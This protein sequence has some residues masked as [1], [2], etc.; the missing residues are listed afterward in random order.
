MIT[1]QQ[2]CDAEGAARYFSELDDYYR[3]GG[4]APAELVGCGATRLGLAGAFD[5][6]RATA[7]AA[8][9]RGEVAGQRIGNPARHRA[10]YDLTFSA[11]KS[12]SV[13]ALVAGDDR[14]AAAHDRAAR[15]ALAHIEAHALVTR[16]RGADGKGYEWRQVEGIT[17]VFRHTTNRRVE[18]DLHSHIVIANAGY[19]QTTG[20]WASIDGKELFAAQREAGTLYMAELA[21][22]AREA[23]H[24]IDWTINAQGHPSF[25]IRD[26]PPELSLAFSTRTQAIEAELARRGLTRETASPDAKQAATLATRDKKLVGVDRAAL[27]ESWRALAREHGYD[28]DKRHGALIGNDQRLAAS[29]DAV[30]R[31][32]EHLSERDARFSRRDLEHECRIY[33]QGHA[34]DADLAAAIDRAQRRGD[35]IQRPSWGRTAGGQRGHRSGFTTAEGVKTERALLETAGKLERAN[36]A[37]LIDPTGKAPLS[38]RVTAR[39]IERAIAARESQNGRPMTDEQRAATAAI[40]CSDSRLQVLGG[41]A[42][43]AKTTSCLAAVADQARANGATVRAMAPTS[44]AAST[45]GEALGS[46]GE[47]VASVLHEQAKPARPDARELWIVDESGMM[48]ARDT[49]DLLQRAE[50]T[51]AT[52]I[53]SGDTKQIGSVGAGAAYS[54]LSASVRPEH[55][56]QL[57]QIVRQKNETLRGAVYDALSGR[58][59]EALQKADTLEIRTR[60]AQITAAAERYQQA[61]AAGKSALVVTLSRADR[62]DVN[63]EIHDQRVAAGQVRDEREVQILD[64]KQWTAAQRS[65]AARYQTGDVIVWGAAHRRGPDRGEQTT[66]VESRDGLVTIQREDGSRWT[67]NPRNMSRFDVFDARALAVGRGDSIVTRSAMH[68]ADGERLANGTRLEVTAV[69]GD[70]M[71]VRDEKGHQHTLDTHRGLHVD[72]GY[73]MTAD[74]AQGKTADESIG[75]IRAGQENLAELARLYVIISRARERGVVITDD[76]QKLAAVL[77]RNT[78]QC[79]QALETAAD[80]D[81]PLPGALAQ[82]LAEREAERE[83]RLPGLPPMMA[84]PTDPGVVAAIERDREQLGLDA[85]DPDRDLD[86]QDLE[87]DLDFDGPEMG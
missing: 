55:K 35:L 50:R 27:V 33:A 57:T 21:R 6:T 22:G 41:H 61:Q 87:Q 20:R 19:D 45:L 54:Q 9:L 40:L 72:H 70:R 26:V 23:G 14:L 58:V 18:P 24:E 2:L 73:A 77:E 31:A 81:P 66:V 64:S 65:D 63:K 51:G 59:R 44:S 29:D 32:I 7:F 53:L 39:A 60:D 16:Q 28:L 82:W 42:G 78:G 68:N 49:K 69:R 56:H 62:A 8:A 38:D 15:A 74:Q 11:P 80:R 10:G 46:R 85:P 76:A 86:D 13:A 48:S 79:K 67:F 4:A 12:F 5:K 47:T 36:G 52:V 71:T 84:E 34:S 43:T 3:E 37:R 83:E 17:G 1:I 75:V 25:E 30:K